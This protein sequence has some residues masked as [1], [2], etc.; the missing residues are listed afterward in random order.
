M[1]IEKIKKTGHGIKKEVKKKL[2]TY[3]T[4]GFGLV[5]GLAWNDAIKNLI[6][7]VFPLTQNTLLA[8]FIYALAITIMLAIIT[9]YL[10]RILNKEEAEEKKLEEKK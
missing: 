7:Y 8:K 9:Y 10:N 1:S 2:L 3:I 4:A 5:V 6:E